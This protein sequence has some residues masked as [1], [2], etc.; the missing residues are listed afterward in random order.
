LAVIQD[1]FGPE[2]HKT[3]FGDLMELIRVGFNSVEESPVDAIDSY[4]KE[5]VTAASFKE[6]NIK[7]SNSLM[8]LYPED[9]R[10]RD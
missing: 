5:A 10:K 9:D 3:A 2:F 7:V 8:Y 6:N 1:K 4:I